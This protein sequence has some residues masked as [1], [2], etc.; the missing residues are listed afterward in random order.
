MTS[1]KKRNRLYPQFGY[2]MPDYDYSRCRVLLYHSSGLVA[3]LIQWQTRSAFAHAAI[4]LPDGRTIGALTKG[5]VQFC[6]VNEDPGVVAFE[7]E[8]MTADQW[9]TACG[10]AA[11]QIGEKY[12]WWGIIRFVSRESMPDNDRWFCSELVFAAI[13][14]AGVNLLE[15]VPASEVS[16]GMMSFSPKLILSTLPTPTL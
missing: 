1:R 11:K 4:M 3:K 10:F 15:R 8:G 16:P 5:G 7:V 2:H 14:A 13:Q 6:P 9:K 12:D